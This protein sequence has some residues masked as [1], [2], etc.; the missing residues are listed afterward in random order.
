MYSY[1]FV[2][3]S[4]ECRTKKSFSVCEEMLP[5]FRAVLKFCSTNRLFKENKDRPSGIRNFEHSTIPFKDSLTLVYMRPAIC[6]PVLIP[7][8]WLLY[9]HEVLCK[10]SVYLR[11]V[12]VF[13]LSLSFRPAFAFVTHVNCSCRCVSQYIK[14]N[15]IS[16][17]MH[18]TL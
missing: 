18:S 7:V 1:L 4:D 9:E 15:Y 17:I 6:F 5:L 12:F 8:S 11:W 16:L 2:S 3:Y 10:I 13:V 14:N